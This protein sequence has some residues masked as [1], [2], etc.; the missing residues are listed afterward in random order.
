MEALLSTW[1]P[2][3]AII[4]V[5]FWTNNMT[6]KRIDDLR[7]QMERDYD[8]LWNKFDR[9]ID[10]VVEN[11]SE[12]IKKAFFF[13]THQPIATLGSQINLEF[14][15]LHKRIEKLEKHAELAK[16]HAELIDSKLHYHLKHYTRLERSK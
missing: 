7:S 4:A 9:K 12:D 11:H 8:K 5:V 15:V 6:N 10:V 13:N 1:L 3:A 16:L 14:R 2:P